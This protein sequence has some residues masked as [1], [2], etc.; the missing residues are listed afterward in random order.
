MIVLC[1]QQAC[2]GP[3][4]V[5]ARCARSPTTVPGPGPGRA[6]DGSRD[7]ARRRPRNC[8]QKVTVRAL[9]PHSRVINFKVSAP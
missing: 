6:A 1:G 9:T 2:H 3:A 8:C 4:A 5:G 7:P